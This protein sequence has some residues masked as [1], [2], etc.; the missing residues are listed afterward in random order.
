M[1]NRPLTEAEARTMNLLHSVLRAIYEQVAFL[2]VPWRVVFTIAPAALAI[3]LLTPRLL[4]WLGRLA[5]VAVTL[6]VSVLA[7]SDFQIG[8]WL[9]RRRGVLRERVEDAA[10]TLVA[11]VGRAMDA[12]ARHRSPRRLIRMGLFAVV[13]LPV[14]CWYGGSEADP[15]TGLRRQLQRGIV[16]TVA[17]DVWM[18]TGAWPE[19]ATLQPVKAEPKPKP[20]PRKGSG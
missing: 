6:V 12:L 17:F 14:V 16:S 4:R 1:R 5:T 11:A 19:T 3:F 18:R 20:K 13:A 2:P 10:V 7:W 8:R 15:G 9:R